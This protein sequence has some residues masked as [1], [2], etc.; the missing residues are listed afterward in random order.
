MTRSMFI[1]FCFLLFFGGRGGQRGLSPDNYRK[2]P[3]TL[4]MFA[5]LIK[6][7]TFFYSLHILETSKHAFGNPTKYNDLN[8]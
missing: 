5:M 8:I 6:I 7:K 4:H 1:L 2:G 3:V